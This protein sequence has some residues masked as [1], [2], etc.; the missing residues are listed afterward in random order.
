MFMYGDFFVGAVVS[1]D[2]NVT[3]DI[4]W[5]AGADKFNFWKIISGDPANTYYSPL[6]NSDLDVETRFNDTTAIDHHDIVWPPWDTYR[7]NPLGLVVTQKS[8]AWSGSLVDDFV[9]FEYE[10]TNVGEND[11]E[12]VYVG[13]WCSSYGWFS[14]NEQSDDL[15]GFLADFPSPD[16]CDYDDT[17]RI[18]YGMDDD[19]DPVQNRFNSQSR[20]GVVGVMLLGASSPNVQVGYSW[21]IWNAD[22]SQ[23]YGP[24]R[25]GTDDEPF[26][27]F[28]SS[29]AWPG[30]DRNLYYIMSHPH[31]AY[32]Q[33]FSAVDHYGWLPPWI[34]AAEYASGWTYDMLYTF[35]PFELPRKDKI[36]F[37]IA[38]VGGDNVHNDPTIKFNPQ[39]PQYYY[40]Q[41]DFS[42]L[43]EN[44][45]WAQ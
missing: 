28:G 5:S 10:M 41:L 13:V 44:A 24:R 4:E 19:G 3:R 42:E 23:A 36:S 35:G 30:S 18:A 6:A 17:L 2:T 34:D 7:H 40:D 25:R 22:W 33:M 11:L 8:M 45:R 16:G 39:N 32:D 29:L 12:E 15:T 14:L 9:L 38:V 27:S 26:R 1:R 37:T 21:H 31:I 43:A 20:R